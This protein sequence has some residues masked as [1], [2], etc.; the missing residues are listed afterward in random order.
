MI[1]REEITAQQRESQKQRARASAD[2]E[3]NFDFKRRKDVVTVT[4]EFLKSLTSDE[5]SVLK[6]LDLGDKFSLFAYFKKAEKFFDDDLDIERVNSLF[7]LSRKVN[8]AVKVVEGRIA[9]PMLQMLA[10]GKKKKA[11]LDDMDADMSMD[12]EVDTSMEPVKKSKSA[13][14]KKAAPKGMKSTPSAT[15]EVVVDKAAVL[16][17]LKGTTPEDRKSVCTRL[18]K[19]VA[20]DEAAAE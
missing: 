10:E 11:A 3:R 7:R 4:P 12:M 15:D 17:F 13:G 8:R 19:L 20:S 5:R 14:D 16:K 18:Q 2:F 1:T 6:V 9:F